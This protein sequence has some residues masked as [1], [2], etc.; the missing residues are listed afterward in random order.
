LRHEQALIDKG[1]VRPTTPEHVENGD[2]T[3]SQFEYYCYRCGHHNSIQT[4]IPEAPGYNH[5]SLACESCGDET[6]VLLSACPSKSC[7]SFVYWINDL[8]IP[9]LVKTFAKYFVHNTQTVI[10]RAAMKGIEIGIDTTDNFPLNASC[11]CGSRFTVEI[12]I[13]DLD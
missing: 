11:S 7:D 3:V 12:S 1:L 8:A 2:R 13:P 9:Q 10:D 5:E 6:H 4:E